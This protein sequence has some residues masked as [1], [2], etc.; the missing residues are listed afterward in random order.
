MKRGY[1][2]Y[3]KKKLKKEFNN[4]SI[5]RSCWLKL[6]TFDDR[7]FDYLF[8][9]DRQETPAKCVSVKPD[10]NEEEEYKSL[11]EDVKREK[12]NLLNYEDCDDDLVYDLGGNL[13]SI[14]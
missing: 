14:N 8:C 11:V 1:F 2:I 10:D 3:C 4:K 12:Q 5:H 7:I 13:I 6:R 9:I